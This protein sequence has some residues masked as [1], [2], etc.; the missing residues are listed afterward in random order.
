MMK[1]IANWDRKFQ[2]WQYSVSHSVL[3][4]RSYH[5]QQYATRIDI[6]FPNVSLM[7]LEPSYEPLEIHEAGP[8]EVADLLG[9]RVGKPDRGRLFLL[10]HGA[11][12]V[13]AADCAWH[14]DQGDHRT[15][16]RFGPLRGTD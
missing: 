13:R 9:D 1:E 4:L 12:Y 10:N 14:E 11:G 15:P 7:R 3:L 5:A 8:E 2:V 6:V 16:S